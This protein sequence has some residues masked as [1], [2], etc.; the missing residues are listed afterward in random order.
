MPCPSGGP[1]SYAL[2]AKLPLST[3][4][5]AQDCYWP[6]APPALAAC[7]RAQVTL[8]TVNCLTCCLVLRQARTFAAGSPPS[9]PDPLY[10]YMSLMCLQSGHLPAPAVWD[11]LAASALR[12]SVN[13]VGLQHHWQWAYSCLLYTSDA[14]DE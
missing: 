4:V 2:P 6:P 13:Q 5:P 10:L 8:G 3:Q 14:A 1:A 9:L 12:I 11:F 7:Q